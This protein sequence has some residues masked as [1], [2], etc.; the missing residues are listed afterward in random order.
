MRKAG[1]ASGKYEG[2]E[3]LLMV[4][5]N[6][7]GDRRTAEAV[8]DQ[9]QRLGF[10]IRFQPVT[11]ETMYTKFCTV[12]KAKVAVCPN[13]GFAKDFYD[14]V[15][16][17]DPAFNGENIPPVGNPNFPQLDV[18]EINRAIDRARL[19][20][21]PD[22]RAKAWGHVDRMVTEQAAAVPW[23]WDNRPNVRSANVNWVINRFLGATDLAF[24]SIEQ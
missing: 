17:L 15:S 24:T 23:L 11:Q 21:D 8:L 1:Y 6:S 3:R 18:P 12:P 20:A 2:K 19:V 10:R 22:E 14:P 13:T 4:G 16:L 9:L 7:G 5:V